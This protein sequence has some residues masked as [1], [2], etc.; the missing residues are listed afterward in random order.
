MGIVAWCT[1]CAS[2]GK[3]QPDLSRPG[4]RLYGVDDA[5]TRVIGSWSIRNALAPSGIAGTHGRR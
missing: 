2:A 5:A 3:V 4:K 1:G